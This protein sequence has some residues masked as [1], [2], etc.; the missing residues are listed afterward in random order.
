MVRKKMLKRKLT[1]L[2]GVLLLTTTAYGS[3]VKSDKYPVVSD[4]NIKLGAYA[5]FEAG[6]STQSHLKSSEKNLSANKNGF[7]FY[8]DTALFATIS[9]KHEGV[10][11]GSKIILVPTAKRK[12]IPS[13]N[14]SHIFLESDFGRVEV[15]SPIP[16]ATNMM[17]SDGG[18]PNKYIK[19]ST[20][21][22]KQNKEHAPLFLTGDGHLLGDEIVADFDKAK[23]SNEP[24]RTI[25]YYTPKFGLNENTKVQVGV[26]YTPDSSN[27]GA[28]SANEQSTGL[29]TKKIGL[30]NLN[31]FEIDR[32]V[33]D[34]V[35][36]G[37]KLEQKFSD[38][39]STQI[40]IT[41]E[42][43]KTKGKAK[44]F[45][46]KNDKNPQEYK[47]ANLRSYNIGGELRFSDFTFNAC[48]GNLGKSFSTTEF[49][50]TGTKSYYYNAG[51]AYKYN[52]TTTKLSYF[53]SEAHKNK[54][55]SVK[56]NIS[57]ILA[58]GLKPYAEISSYTL[59]GK[60]EFHNE[61]KSKSTRGTVALLG[62]KLT[63]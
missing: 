61:L 12:N 5:A 6:G 60:P 1:N 19:K 11:Y 42:Y 4:L 59:K 56:L 14:G 39:I 34:A 55:S 26:S 24:P 2:M 32:S 35:T 33:T 15:G 54:V 43:G 50:K 38:D 27:T 3:E 17:I 16:V 22:L 25:N 31:K 63:L 57:H 62:L 18:I 30:A 44:K 41:G 23:Y 29:D 49:H 10:E 36:A 53:G 28:G 48:Y 8:N 46:T 45:A 7:L 47:L 58:P 9:N 13:Y 52:D 20:A 21:H 40:A 51:V 37:I